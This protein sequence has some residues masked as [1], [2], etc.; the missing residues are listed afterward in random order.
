MRSF[1]T[2]DPSLHMLNPQS[3]INTSQTNAQRSGYSADP[4]DGAY[5]MMGRTVAYPDPNDGLGLRLFGMGLIRP[6]TQAINGGIRAVNFAT[7]SV[8]NAFLTLLGA[9]GVA[10]L[11]KSFREKGA[12]KATA[13]LAALGAAAYFGLKT[14]VKGMDGQRTQHEDG[15]WQ[16]RLGTTTT[17]GVGATVL[18]GLFNGG[19]FGSL[20]KDAAGKA[21]N[22]TANIPKTAVE[23]VKKIFSA[24]K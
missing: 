6:F 7:S 3:K 9:G 10:L 4:Y 23:V 21:W 12:L 18:L 22:G 24:F 20:I 8:N 16:Y 1:V 14:L 17:Y 19:N 2:L 13:G 5:P 11:I 15:D